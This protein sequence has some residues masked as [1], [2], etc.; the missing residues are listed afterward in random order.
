MGCTPLPGG[1][2]AC[3]RGGSSQRCSSCG[4]WVKRAVLCDAPIAS[5]KAGKTCDRVLCSSCA[6]RVG[7]NRD[8]CPAHAR[9]EKLADAGASK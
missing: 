6:V 3:S 9:A 5:A 1:G 7:P 4:S 8:L 2:F